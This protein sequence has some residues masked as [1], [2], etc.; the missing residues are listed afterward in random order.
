VA[1]SAAQSAVTEDVFINRSFSVRLSF[2]HRNIA[3]SFTWID[4]YLL[5]YRTA[6]RRSKTVY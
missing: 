5:I 3:L 6:M 2:Y 4:F 1:T